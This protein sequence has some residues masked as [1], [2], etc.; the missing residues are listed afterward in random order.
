MSE[1][2]IHVR[3]E[4][5]A[6][7]DD[8]HGIRV[9]AGGTVFTQL[10]RAPRNDSDD[11]LL[12]PP[13]QLAF[14]LVDNWWRLRWEC[15]PIGH[16]STGWR[17]AHDLSSIG[18][19][20]S[21]PH[22]EV[23]GDV[24]RTGLLS[25][26]DP[27][28]VV[29]PVRYLVDAIHYVEATDFECE[30]DRFLG[31]VGDD[32]GGFGS[33]REAL[34]GLISALHDERN[35]SEMA[36]WRRLE[37]RL[38]FDVDEGPDELIDTVWGVAQDYGFEAVEEAVMAIQG[39]DASEVLQREITAARASTSVC[40]F[41]AVLGVIEP[42]L[43]RPDQPP[44]IV[45]EEVAAIVR[46]KLGV[47]KGPLDDSALADLLGV[48]AASFQRPARP[49]EHAYGLRL[50]VDNHYERYYISLHS[51]SSFARRFE[52]SRALGDLLWSRDERMG[53]LTKSST[54]RQKFQRAFAQSL[55]CPFEDLKGYLDMGNLEEEE[56]SEA[57]RHF[58]VDD[59]VVQTVLVNK[60]AIQRRHFKELVEAA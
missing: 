59:R 35:D 39:S 9:R 33:D 24:D 31:E 5:E 37:A 50:A 6:S 29:G 4:A 34:R 11:H 54:A 8:P 7:D 16:R 2:E 52:L 22:L 56:I 58:H 60:G 1:F 45:A 18:G 19:G 27:V 3:R 41:S 40:D 46:E 26:S 43:H 23:W 14:W 48:S 47:S 32:I 38:G 25:R 12:A 51:R 13:A 36:G 49:T 55:L 42:P 53:P 44:W 21:W 28:G 15:V 30:V 17:L 57:A 10:L 20:Y